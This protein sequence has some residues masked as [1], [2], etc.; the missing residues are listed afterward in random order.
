MEQVLPHCYVLSRLHLA[1]PFHRVRESM[2]IRLSENGNV[3]TGFI[4][5][6]VYDVEREDTLHCMIIACAYVKESA[7][8]DAWTD[9]SSSYPSLADWKR[10]ARGDLDDGS[11]VDV[12]ADE[13]V[14]HGARVLTGFWG[15][16]SS[17]RV[18]ELL[19][20]SNAQ[21]GANI[22][23]PFFTDKAVSDG[24][25][26]PFPLFNFI[27]GPHGM[28]KCQKEEDIPEWSSF[29]ALANVEVEDV[30]VDDEQIIVGQDENDF[31]PRANASAAHAHIQEIWQAAHGQ[32]VRNDGP[33]SFIPLV[34]DGEESSAQTWTWYFVSWEDRDVI[35]NWENWT[36]E[37]WKN[38][39]PH[40]LMAKPFGQVKGC[41]ISK[42]VG[43][44]QETRPQQRAWDMQ[45]PGVVS[46]LML[47]GT[48][49]QGQGSRQYKGQRRD[50]N[51]QQR[52]SR[53][54][55]GQRRDNPQQG[56]SAI[57]DYSAIPPSG[58]TAGKKGKKRKWA[59]TRNRDNEPPLPLPRGQERHPIPR[60]KKALGEVAK[61]VRDY[62]VTFLMMDANMALFNVIDAV[63]ND[64]Q[65]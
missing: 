5:A 59:A 46:Y 62:N 31:S 25:P 43:D 13:I 17:E 24:A 28:V 19:T 30:W 50:Y 40:E 64:G 44:G 35:E 56:A 12:F 9:S 29:A 23:C 60:G 16:S 55:E 33:P 49:V 41:S 36:E 63:R 61:L 6:A 32:N 21:I 15:L 34:K 14:N 38:L 3:E 42:R 1:M 54:Y 10:G 53:Q 47:L 26:S 20:R 7:M 48:S 37:H 58:P 27:Y 2:G 45:V 52:A 39:V 11:I 22:F 51:R 57:T 65:A 4:D 8:T 18:S